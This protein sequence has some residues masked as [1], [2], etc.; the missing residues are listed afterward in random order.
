MGSGNSMADQSDRKRDNQDRCS[1]GG[2]MDEVEWCDPE[3]EICDKACPIYNSVT[4]CAAAITKMK[5]R[6]C[7]AMVDA[8]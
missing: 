5:C 1:C 3:N 7:G 6:K 8:A 4:L 2:Y